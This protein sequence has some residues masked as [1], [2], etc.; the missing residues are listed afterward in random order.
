MAGAKCAW[1]L[2][3]LG[4]RDLTV[5]DH[6]KVESHNIPIGN[7]V[8]D[9]RHLGMPKVMALKQRLKEYADVNVV[10]LERKWQDDPLR[11]TVLACVDDMETRHS[12]WE[13]VKGR[14]GVDLL[15]DTR[16][17]AD[18]VEVFAIQPFHPKDAE[19]YA[20]Y[21][22]YGS[23][24]AAQRTCGRHGAPHVADAVSMAVSSTLVSWWTRNVKKSVHRY[25]VASLEQLL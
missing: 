17:S 3:S 25:K 11:G 22:A 14:I 15:I 1:T 21:V 20:P 13:A 9:R 16:I 6:D 5:Y 19:L 4:I 24:D 23:R 12:I 2:A 10:A 18:F 7:G 8:Y